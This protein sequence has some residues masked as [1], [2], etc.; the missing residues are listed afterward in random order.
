MDSKSP[1]GPTADLRTWKERIA[2]YETPSRPRSIWQIVNSC[3]P[4]VAFWWLAWRL[5]D[6][7]YWATFLAAIPAAGF[8]VRMFIISHDCG[9]G[10]FFRSR[11]AAAFWGT[12]CALPSFIPYH[13]WRREHAVHHA[14]SGNLDRRGI[15]DIATMTVEEYR[16]ASRWTRLKYRLYRHPLVMLGIGPLYTF[17]VSYRFWP[18]G[19]SARVRRSVIVTN[20]LLAAGVTGMSM[21]VGWKDFLVVHGT[22]LAISGTTGVWLFYVQHQFEDVYWERGE[23]WDYVRQSIEGSSFYRL[24]RI[25]QWFSGN[26]GFH[27]IHHLSSR[28]PNYYLEKVQKAIPELQRVKPVTLRASLRSLRFRLFDE[29]R[30]RLVGFDEVPERERRDDD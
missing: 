9:H 18:K 13:A 8:L 2:P 20:V 21:L 11:R 12:L 17:V 1:G 15:G 10:A 29:R 24:P 30:R 16:N 27:H 6:V 19:A 26:I 4:F 7:G 22:I 28:I 25:L 14:T 3:V 5:L 23:N